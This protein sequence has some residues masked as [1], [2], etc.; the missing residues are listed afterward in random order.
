LLKSLNLKRRAAMDT[1]YPLIQILSDRQFHSGDELGELLG[2][3]RAAVWKRLKRL[4]EFGIEVHSVKGKG[5]RLANP[6][7]LIDK[8]SLEIELSRHFPELDLDID[9]HPSTTSTN[10]P[11]MNHGLVRDFRIVLAEH[12]SGGRG[13]RGR[14]WFS[15]FGQSISL[16]T[17]TDLDSGLAGLDRLS[18]LIA[19][20]VA[21]SLD[22]MGVENIGIKWP[23]DVYS[24]GRKIAGIL[25]EARSNPDGSTRIGVGIG[26]NYAVDQLDPDL[27]AQPWVSVKQAGAR[28][29]EKNNL[30]S[31]LLA[32]VLQAHLQLFNNETSDFMRRWNQYDYLTDK[33]I[34]LQR[35]QQIV[36]GKYCGID[37]TGRL[38]VDVD[39]SVEAFVAGE[40]TLKP[41]V[42]HDDH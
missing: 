11:A 3:T 10:D 14:Q 32:K 23:N 24:D 38:L 27:V 40:V 1:L 34:A 19:I 5:Y 33:D 20:A 8:T 26:V 2:I 29:V 17:V 9:V 13:R 4:A 41:M 39:G 30:L 21:E 6:I 25:L 37:E 31:D 15:P 16:T 42:A 7:E 35:G 12:Q 22:G 36:E 28:S 18:L